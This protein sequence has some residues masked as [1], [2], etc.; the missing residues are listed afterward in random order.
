MLI[1]HYDI[2]ICYYN[3]VTRDRK[4]RLRGYRFF[5]LTFKVDEVVLTPSR[6]LQDMGGAYRDG[7]AVAETHV[8]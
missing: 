6:S 7:E 4:A 5:G 3:S 1:F 8:S 2:S